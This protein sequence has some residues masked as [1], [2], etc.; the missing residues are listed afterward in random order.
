MHTVAIPILLNSVQVEIGQIGK[1]H[2]ET[3]KPATP[4]TVGAVEMGYG[5]A[6]V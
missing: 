5:E 6:F 4:E 3:F 1:Y 2:P